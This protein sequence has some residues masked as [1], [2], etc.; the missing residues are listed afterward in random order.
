MLAVRL[1]SPYPSVLEI[2]IFGNRGI[3]LCA[4][5]I[6][7]Y[8]AKLESLTLIIIPMKSAILLSLQIF[9]CEEKIAYSIQFFSALYFS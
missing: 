5:R 4:L 8:E 2:V 3:E 7:V 6:Y 1:S 9:M